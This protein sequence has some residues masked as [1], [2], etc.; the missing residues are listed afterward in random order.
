MLRNLNLARCNESGAKYGCL[1]YP[2]EP[3][4]L[5]SGIYLGK[6]AARPAPARDN[7]VESNQVSG[8]GMRER[9]VV[10]APGVSLAA[11]QVERNRCG[12]Q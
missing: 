11:N 8:Y 2:E 7:V 12:V 3:D 10:A 5:R 6:G 1:Y 4:M 9:C